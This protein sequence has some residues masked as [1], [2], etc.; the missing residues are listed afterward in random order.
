[1]TGSTYPFGRHSLLEALATELDPAPEA[2]RLATERYD[3]L[4]SWMKARAADAGYDIEVYPQGSRNLGTTNRNPFT[5]EFDIDL[6]FRVAVKKSNITQSDLNELVRGWLDGYVTARH[7]VGHPLAPDSL[8]AGKRA[9]TLH[10]PQFHLDVL[11]V[12]PDLDRELLP[13]EGDPSWLTDKNLT[14]W[15]AT[16]PEASLTLS[17]ASRRPSSSQNAARLP[18]RVESTLK[19]CRLTP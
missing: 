8:E 7:Q 4:G 5:D 18:K 2:M 19:T 14:R 6:V 11:P 10:Y 13:R 17:A 12:V 9:W 3:D 15:Q 1:M 16:N